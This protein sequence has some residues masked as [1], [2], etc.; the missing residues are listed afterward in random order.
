MFKKH[1]KFY[2]QIV[3][4]ICIS[5]HIII[6]TNMSEININLGLSCDI[7]Q[8][9]TQIGH[10]L[11][12]GAFND[13]TFPDGSRFVSCIDNGQVLSAYNHPTKWHSASVD[14][15]IGGQTAKSEKP[16]GQWAVAIGRAGLMNRK[17]YYNSW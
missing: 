10:G 17:T 12:G 15:G 1:H 16:P 11:S 2:D 14:G 3:N 13:R 8:L 4:S 5:Y 9:I 6:I 7:N